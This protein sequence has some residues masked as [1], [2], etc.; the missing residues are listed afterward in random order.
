MGK[1]L[2]LIEILPTSYEGIISRYIVEK[3]HEAEKE[4]VFYAQLPNVAEAARHAAL[5]LTPDG[6]RHPH[7]GPFRVQQETLDAWTDVV[8][9]NLA[10]LSSVGT[11]EELHDRLESLRFNGVGPLIIYDTAFRLGAK[12]GLEPRLV[13][14][15][16]GTRDGASSAGAE[17]G[18]QHELHDLESRSCASGLRG[19]PVRRGG[20]VIRPVQQTPSGA[21]PIDQ[22]YT[23]HIAHSGIP[24]GIGQ[25]VAVG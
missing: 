1:K 17:P 6:K 19:Q 18:G 16:R 8:L 25:S 9:R 3:R 4:R 13:Y 7:Q 11:F 24:R 15:H 23:G 14:L 21:V 10:W 2:P 20:I 5:A 12:L 22:E